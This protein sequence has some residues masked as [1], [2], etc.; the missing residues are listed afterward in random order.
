[1]IVFY[2]KNGNIS[3]EFDDDDNIVPK[4]W[5]LVGDT[6]ISLRGFKRK[7]VRFTNDTIVLQNRVTGDIQTLVKNC[8]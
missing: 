2:D 7:I 6:L 5:E 8:K 4:K 1:M 3:G